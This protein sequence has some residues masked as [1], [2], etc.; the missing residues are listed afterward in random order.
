[1]LAV[2]GVNGVGGWMLRCRLYDTVLRSVHGVIAERADRIAAGLQVGAGGQMVLDHR[3]VHDEFRS[4][5]SGWYWQL[6]G[7]PQVE[8]SRSLWDSS[9]QTSEVVPLDGEHGLFHLTGPRNELL[10]GI[11]R[12]VVL[13]GKKFKLYV[14]A[15]GENTRV[16][17]ARIDRILLI[18][19]AGLS[20]ALLLAMCL[21]ARV[22]LN[23]LRRL[24]AALKRVQ[25]GVDNRVGT[26]YGLDLDPL[27][28]EIDE[29][30]DRNA[31]IVGRSRSYVA[32]LSHAL[33]K[34]LALLA[35]DA[36]GDAVDAG[37]VHKQVGAMYQL[38]ERHLSR[39]GSG[40]GDR[41]RIN[42]S[43]CMHG[44]VSLMQKLHVARSLQWDLRQPDQVFWRGEQTDFEEMLGNL[45]DNAGKWARSRVEVEVR[46]LD[47]MGESGHGPRCSILEILISDDG[48]GLDEGEIARARRRGQRFDESVEGSGLGLAIACDIAETYDGQLDLSRSELGGLQV[49]LK[50]PR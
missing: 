13:N 28:E 6:E 22:G 31:R 4:I 42:V 38:I 9:L 30:L 33:K 21:Q 46:V 48:V 24:H 37:M 26:G 5:F 27:A 11:E 36:K 39:A 16:D 32:D 20:T 49:I 41:R 45:L 44:L 23:P 14:F 40:A 50:L 29:V 3:L 47:A 35:A 2:L 15:P 18:M 8:R 17:L 7:L 34:P 12:D 10:L 43:D 1:M 25:D 19:L